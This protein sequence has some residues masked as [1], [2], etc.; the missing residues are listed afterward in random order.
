MNYAEVLRS[1]VP[2]LEQSSI[3][4]MITGSIA[5]AYYGRARATYDLD[6]VISATPEKLETL[7]QLLPKEQYYAVLQDALDAHRHH[8]M[9][10][11]LDTISGWK[12]DLI[13]KK[14]APFHEEAFRRRTAATFEGVATCLISAEDLILS[15][16][17]WGKLGESE[18]QIRDS[19]IVLQKGRLKLDLPYIEKWVQEL[20]LTSEWA[21]ACQLA[22]EPGLSSA[23]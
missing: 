1:I 13:F 6:I 8:S 2:K 21:R 3:D 10:N 4:Y 16:L 23:G 14:P 20:G 15:K 22:N 5:A 12:I 18:R 19:A 11:V 17:E 7:I 9:F